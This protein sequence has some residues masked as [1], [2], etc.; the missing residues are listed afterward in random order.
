MPPRKKQEN[1][2]FPL[3]TPDFSTDEE[4]KRDCQV[5]VWGNNMGVRS[6]INW[7]R[8]RKS[9]TVTET[10]RNEQEWSSDD[11][12]VTINLEQRIVQVIQLPDNCKLGTITVHRILQGQG[13]GEGIQTARL[14]F[15][16]DLK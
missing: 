16:W 3:R 9:L 12:R 15:T 13:R 11:G 10:I 8:N 6:E 7:T 2:L 4:G 5:T 14:R 1:P